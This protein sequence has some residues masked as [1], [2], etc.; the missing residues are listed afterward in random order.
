[1]MATRQ[2]EVTSD[3]SARRH[4]DDT[5]NGGVWPVARRGRPQR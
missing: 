3:A 4:A 1:M 5:G 2:V